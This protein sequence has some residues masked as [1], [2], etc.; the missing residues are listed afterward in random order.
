MGGAYL[1]G[2]YVE[3]MQ[4]VMP[5]CVMWGWI[6]SVSSAGAITEEENRWLVQ[7]RWCCVICSGFLA[8]FHPVRCLLGGFLS[9]FVCY[10]WLL[11][12]CL[13]PDTCPPPPLHFTL[14]DILCFL[15]HGSF[16][17][18]NPPPLSHTNCCISL[19]I[20]P[21]QLS[22]H[23]AS[24]CL[25]CLNKLPPPHPLIPTSMSFTSP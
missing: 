22:P 17:I 13:L 16:L 9:V 7:H 20:C 24:L 15:S 10:Q 8:A 4:K 12:L 18:D 2:T 14:N 3:L 6:F 25:I 23:A 11:C 1:L 19:L 5:W 21:V